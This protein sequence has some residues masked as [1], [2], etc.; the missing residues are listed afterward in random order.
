MREPTTAMLLA[1]ILNLPDWGYLP[2]GWQAMIDYV[3]AEQ[4]S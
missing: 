4:L 1:A 3:A 2:D